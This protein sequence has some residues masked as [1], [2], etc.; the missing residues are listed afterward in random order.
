MPI[1]EYRC[2]GCGQVSEILIGV[3]AEP[4]ELLCASCGGKNLE[5]ILSAPGGFSIKRESGGTHCGSEKTCC[6]RDERCEKPP[7]GNK[8]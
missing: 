1:Y 3:G 5:K 6:G 2:L 4:A 8:S 7:C